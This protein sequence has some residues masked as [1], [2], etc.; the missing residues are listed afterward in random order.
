MNLNVK[1]NAVQVNLN[2]SSSSLGEMSNGFKKFEEVGAVVMESKY[3][4]KES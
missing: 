4:F 3:M 2:E 1:F